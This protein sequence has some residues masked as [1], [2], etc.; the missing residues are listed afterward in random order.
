MESFKFKKVKEVEGK[1]EYRVQIWNKFA[2]LE[3]LDAE[4]DINSARE[5]ISENVKYLAKEN[6]DYYELN[7]WFHEEFSILLHRRK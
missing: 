1:E 3:N 4:V 6:T 2:A 7:L 5:T